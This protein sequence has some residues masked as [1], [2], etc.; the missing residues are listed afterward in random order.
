MN[1]FSKASLKDS[2]FVGKWLSV[3]MEPFKSIKAFVSVHALLVKIVSHIPKSNR[4]RLIEHDQY[5]FE[6]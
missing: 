2:V 1:L 5:R 4:L 6:Q 3:G